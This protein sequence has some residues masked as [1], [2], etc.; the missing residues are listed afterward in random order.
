MVHCSHKE[1]W[2]QLNMHVG[3][4]QHTRGAKSLQKM[5]AVVADKRFSVKDKSQDKKRKK[6]SELDNA[7][8]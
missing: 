1:T 4:S 3:N 6:V 7:C 2:G 5:Q 8:Y